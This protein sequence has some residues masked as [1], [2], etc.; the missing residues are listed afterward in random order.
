MENDTLL[1]N[2]IKLE[3]ESIVFKRL[4]SHLQNRTDVQNID[5]NESKWVLQKLFIELVYG[6]I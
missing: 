2:Q 5:P 4:V 1:T 6:S 3:I